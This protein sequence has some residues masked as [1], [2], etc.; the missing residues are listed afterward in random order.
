MVAGHQEQ[1][2]YLLVLL[3][4]PCRQRGGL[5]GLLVVREERRRSSTPVS[6]HWS[7]PRRLA[8]LP[9]DSLVLQWKKHVVPKTLECTM[10]TSIWIWM[11]G[12]EDRE[13]Q[14]ALDDN[15]RL[16]MLEEEEEKVKG[17]RVRLYT[18]VAGILIKDPEILDGRAHQ[19]PISDFLVRSLMPV[20]RQFWKDHPAPAAERVTLAC[21]I[22]GRTEQLSWHS[23]PAKGVPKVPQ[24]LGHSAG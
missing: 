6:Q 13:D 3:W 7:I 21:L 9:A 16:M 19:I 17:G 23:R 10:P 4:K 14:A 1:G 18:Q 5:L 12:R 8:A 15:L 24:L 22:H 20:C 11:F 2:S